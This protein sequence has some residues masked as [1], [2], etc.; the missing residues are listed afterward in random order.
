MISSNLIIF[1]FHRLNTHIIGVDIYQTHKKK[2]T[3]TD[4]SCSR[5]ML[6]HIFILFFNDLNY[7][8][9]K[10]YCV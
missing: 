8:R 2:H 7:E 5:L 1:Y 9:Q 4:A 3:H 10:I 6:I